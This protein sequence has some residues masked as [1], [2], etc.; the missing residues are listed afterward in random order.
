MILVFIGGM[1]VVNKTFLKD[2]IVDPLFGRNKILLV[3]KR[4]C[5]PWVGGIIVDILIAVCVEGL[6]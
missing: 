5:S 2:Y 4:V 6:D 1:Y 3:M